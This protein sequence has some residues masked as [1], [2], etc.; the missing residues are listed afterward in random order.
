MLHEQPQPWNEEIQLDN[1]KYIESETD[2]KGV[3]TGCN[4]YFAK[5]SGYTK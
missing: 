4:D 5:I 1:T 2:T 3:I